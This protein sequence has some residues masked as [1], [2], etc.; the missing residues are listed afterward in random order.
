MHKKYVTILKN[1]SNAGYAAGV[2]FCLSY[3]KQF[4]HRYFWVL[5]NDCKLKD[6][7]LLPLVDLSK[8]INGKS[9]LSST[10]IER[11]TNRV[12]SY[13]GRHNEFLSLSKHFYEGKCFDRLPLTLEPDYL[14][15]ASMF[16]PFSL[17]DDVGYMD[18]NF[19]L[20]CEDIDWSIRAKTKGYRLIVTS[21]SCIFHTLGGTA[22]NLKKTKHSVKALDKHYLES[23][24]YLGT[25]LGKI[26]SIGVRFS[27]VLRFI[28]RI[29]TFRLTDALRV[30]YTS[31]S[32]WPNEHNKR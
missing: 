22:S 30:L 26:K 10:F 6:D 7:A 14:V 31:I 24:L 5:N 27:F 23:T 19:F 16:A 4:N 25:K 8:T 15:G 9:F 20:Y 32:Y 18:E 28:K 12:Q 1:Q 3:A 17:L 13:G 29:M 2:N 11:G 21:K